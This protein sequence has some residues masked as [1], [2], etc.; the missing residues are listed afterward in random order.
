MLIG[1]KPPKFDTFNGKGDPYT[2]LMSYCHK[3][4]GVGRDENIRIKLFIRSLSGEYLTSYT[5]QDPRKWLRWSDMAQD[6]MDRFSFNTNI[7]PD[8]CCLTKITKK[9]TETFHEY[10]LCWRSEVARVQTLM[11]D[12]E[13]TTTFIECQG[14]TI[15]YEKMISMMGQKFTDVARMGEALEEG[16]KSGR[17]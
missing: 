8:R 9:S 11:S 6:F 10:T 15:Y 14:G 13:M 12:S 5:Q 17:I 1:Y 16:I 4:I 7:L 2:H 3:L